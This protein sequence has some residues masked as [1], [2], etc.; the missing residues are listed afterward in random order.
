ML[1]L[2]CL[3][4]SLP[5]VPVDVAF[6]AAAPTVDVHD[7]AEITLDVT[8]AAAANPF[9]DAAVEGQFSRGNGAPL[10]VDGFCDSADG[11]V[12]RIRFMPTQPGQHRY[13]VKYRQG[14]FARTHTGTFTARD[15]KRRGQL[16]VDPKYP[17]HFIWAGTGEHYFWNGTTT[18]YLMGWEDDAVIR[19]AIDRLAALKVNRLRVLVYGRNHDRPWGQPV[20]STADFK[21][22]LNPWPA[23]RPD[24]IKNP[25]FDLTR[26]NV[27]FWQ[28]YERM[29][30]HARERDVIVS[31]IF[32][33]GGQVLPTPFAAYSEDEQR[34]Y[35]YGVARLAAFANLTWDL[36]N[37]HNFHREVPKWCD[38]LGPLVKQWDPYDHLCAA[39]NVIYRTRGATWNDLQLIQRWDGGQNAFMLGE[40]TKQAATGRVIPQVNEEY[41]YEDLWE[42]SPGQRAADTRR[43]CAWEIAMAGCYQTTGET[44]NRGVGFPPD[45]GGGWVGGRGDDSMTMLRGY[46]HLVEFF[47]SF[48]WWRLTPRNELVR[49]G[50]CCLAET[51]K[52]YAVYLPRSTSVTLT[53][54]PG[55][56]HARWFNPRSGQWSDAPVASGPRWTPP[57][58]ADDGDWALLLR[59]DPQLRDTT[60]PTPASVTA[61]L[62]RNEVVITFSKTLD[63]RSIVAANFTLDPA[64]AVR[65]AKPG[66]EPNTVTL[67]TGALTDGARYTLTV[68]DVQDLAS[69]PNRLTNPARVVFDVHD[70]SR[71]I[72]ELRFNEGRGLV[73]ANAGI[74]AGAH[75]TAALTDKQLAWTTNTPPGGDPRALDFGSAPANRAVE[76]AADV[77]P[78]LKGLKSFAISGWVNARSAQVGSGGNRI[79]TAINHGGDGFDLVMTGDGRL[80]LGVNEWPDGSPAK[81]SARQ[82]PAHAEAPAANWR[83]F[84][85]TYDATMSPAEVKFY[86]GT[87]ERQAALDV[88]LAY[89]RGP[90]GEDLGPLAVGHFNRRTRP[91]NA[92]RMFRGLIDEI[93]V[94][95]S[96]LDGTGALTLEQ[97]RALQG[98]V[99]PGAPR[100]ER[101]AAPRAERPAPRPKKL[102]EL[103]VS[104]NRRFLV[105]ADGQPFFYLGDTAWE[106][107]HRLN[108]EE[109][110]RYLANRARHGFTVIQAVVVAELDGLRT[111]NA[112][113]HL[114][115]HDFDSRRPNEAYFAHVDYIVDRAAALGLYIGMLP[116]WGRYVGGAD[117]GRPDA[118]FF[119]AQ[120][121][122]AY[123][124]FLARRYGDQPILWVLGGDRLADNTAAVWTAMAHGIREVVGQRQ[125]ITFHPRGGRSSSQWFHQTGWLDFHMLQSG[126][127][128]QSVNYG[129][130]ERDY[131][132]QPPKPTFDG[133]PAYEYPPDAMP[134][135]R[136]VGALQVRRNAYWAVFAGAHG[137]TYGTHPIWQMYERGRKPL[138]DVV[139]PWHQ[140]L[141]LPGATQL[142]HLKRLMLSRPFLTRIPDQSVILPPVPDGVARVQATRDGRPGQDDATCLMAYFPEHRRVTVNT[143][144]IAAT[145]LRG[146]WYN[147][148]TGAAT[149]LGEFSN[150]QTK[151]FEPPTR[152]AGDDWGLVLDDAARAYPAPGQL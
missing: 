43:R 122:A 35:R 114:P 44:A 52:L 95:G 144:R 64:V 68:R 65:A 79:V 137:H 107:F 18:Y 125:L 77:L 141:D 111:P 73:T 130:V 135:K 96:P 33:I 127:N 57:A 17:E 5:A 41:G 128:A 83:F 38:W 126:H 121:A 1:V 145:T 62:A 76:F 101:P 84:A 36:G 116:S 47:T 4:P 11:S 109:A 66:A 82:I 133:E 75:P 19:Q 118:N 67:S 106:L 110:D 69:P 88:T 14:T 105:Q 140:A 45:T 143:G 34:F 98:P 51:G 72:V 30:R 2:A 134:P 7:F 24:D 39:H 97:I 27:S 37:E 123:G 108:R 104:E 22:Y 74:A 8:R 151:E 91:E 63:P 103:R 139:T 138:W 21:L 60:P 81:S 56:Y 26:F 28:K 150:A 80:Q 16:R 89:D 94:H 117:A 23:A 13:S 53:L 102:P 112:Y 124:R 55:T 136:P 129:P 9:T 146:W 78:A 31:V 3:L 93:R 148:R 25:G 48:D 119:N 49:G 40:R 132:L 86:F 131:A 90:I 147:P 20:K 71:P 149:P 42:K 15:A 87:P 120:N 6:R 29:L 59:H 61:S 99:S 46:G 10:Q 92:D 32:F 100:A 58:P 12:Y 115:F 50:G 54:G 152:A 70:A 85:V 113:G 142:I